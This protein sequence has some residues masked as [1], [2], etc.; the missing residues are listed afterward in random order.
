MGRSAARS[1]SRPARTRRSGR[2]SV[3]TR[4]RPR[5]TPAEAGAPVSTS[6]G[7][8]V[9]TWCPPLRGRSARGVIGSP[10][11]TNVGGSTS[12]S[13]RHCRSRS[14]SVSAMSAACV[15]SRSSSGSS[16]M[17][18]CCGWSSSPRA[19]SRRPSSNSGART[20]CMDLDRAG[21]AP[22]PPG[23]EPPGRRDGQVQRLH[24]LL[25]R[26]EDLQRLLQRRRRVVGALL[27]AQAGEAASS[28]WRSRPISASGSSGLV[29]QVCT[30]M[31]HS[32]GPR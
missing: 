6:P 12:N 9:V 17:K 7:L 27:P 16:A 11:T 21:L 15:A 10:A 1:G 3:T 29:S 18:T 26:P 28:S 23:A 31:S 19:V 24:R 14:R 22:L 25:V 2:V 30:P 4:A 13:C 5:A 20:S 8:T 32:L